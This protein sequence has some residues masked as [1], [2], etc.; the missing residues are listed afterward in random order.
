MES[1]QRQVVDSAKQCM[2]TGDVS[3]DLVVRQT[4]L[5]YDNFVKLM[6]DCLPVDGS[7]SKTTAMK[8]LLVT[9]YDN[10]QVWQQ[11]ELMN[12]SLLAESSTKCSEFPKTKH[13]GLAQN[14]NSSQN[15][16]STKKRDA[17]AR[18]S[19]EDAPKKKTKKK[20]KQ[21]LENNEDE[22]MDV[23]NGDE[24]FG[25]DIENEDEDG[26][27]KNSAKYRKTVVDDTFFKLGQM[28]EFLDKMD[29]KELQRMDGHELPDDLDDEEDDDEEEDIDYFN[30]MGDDDSDPEDIKY[31]DYFDLGNRKRAPAEEIA[32][33]EEIDEEDGEEDEI[34]EA[35]AGSEEE[36]D[37][38]EDEEVNGAEDEDGDAENED[39]EG[40][41]ED[42]D[43]ED[44]DELSKLVEG[45]M[46]NNEVE[47]DVAKSEFELNQE[48]MLEKIKRLE[49]A[50][51]QTKPW[52]LMGEATSNRPINS[53]LEEVVT[54]EH[55]T[56]GAPEITEETTQ[57]L[58]D[59]IIQRI[60]DQIFDDVERK[61][62]PKAQ[63]LEYKKAPQLE[64]EKSK[65]SLAEVYEKEY[66]DK[67]Q[68]DQEDREDEKHVQVREMMTSLFKKLDALSNFLYTP[69]APEPQLKII[70]NTP[71]LRM[72]EV[73]PITMSDATQLAPEEIYQ[74]NK[75]E[76]VGD[77]EKT[78]QNR[79][80]ARR[81][82]KAQ[83]KA[84]AKERKAKEA[85]G[86]DSKSKAVSKLK[87]SSK[88]SFVTDKTA[89]DTS[90]LKS[91]SKFFNEL[92]NEVKSDI[93]NKKS[94]SKDADK[95][96]RTQTTEFLKL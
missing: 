53:L 55:T 38:S 22:L 30:E 26:R 87:K 44:Q 75:T 1:C 70:T 93:K 54:F 94:K 48:K 11:L 31:N 56:Q 36:M 59:L 67:I 32:P 88:S 28:E 19:A 20:S 69:K 14:N 15:S 74:K 85:I 16:K 3:A 29:A 58:E 51:L 60:K 43:G 76:I 7:A 46:E 65:L 47:E 34:D 91:S 5:L 49:Q 77:T 82:K 27:S 9:G 41:D 18:K 73:T 95:K 37:G 39:E 2:D 40:A 50:N 10:E 23:E 83:K 25:E 45:A 62:K 86:V 71:S 17:K 79:A 35:E 90:T 12:S 64:M 78:D 63:S 61:L 6:H 42:E 84:H 4:K 52:Q 96:S 72:E 92:Q 13:F 8:E 33:E 80:N 68:G 81:K 66:T 89:V 57:T 21:T 24:D